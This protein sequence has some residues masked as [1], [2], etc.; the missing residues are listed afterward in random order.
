MNKILNKKL[1]EREHRQKTILDGA[2]KSYSK[3][4]V[5]GITMDNIAQE[6][7]FGKA[8]IYYYFHSKEI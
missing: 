3:Y 4:G 7:D 1:T 2:L 6:S 5:D 8:T